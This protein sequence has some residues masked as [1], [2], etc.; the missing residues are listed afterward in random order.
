MTMTRDDKRMRSPEYNLEIG[1]DKPN[2]RLI[3]AE[4]EKGIQ[5]ASDYTDRNLRA[6]NSWHSRWEGMSPDGRKHAD[7]Q[8]PASEAFPWEGA[9]DTRVRTVNQ[10]IRYYTTVCRFAFSGAKIQAT[11]LRPFAQNRQGRQSN[12]ITNLL[13]YQF[14]TELRSDLLR[15]IPIGFNWRNGYGA[16]L[17]ITDWWQCRRLEKIEINRMDLVDITAEMFGL[18]PGEA[19]WQVQEALSNPSHFDGMVDFVQSL[20]PIMT[21][22]EARKAVEALQREGFTTLRVPKTFRNQPRIWAARPG[23][24]AL[25]LDVTGDLQQEPWF[26]IQERVSETDLFDRIET[27]GYD[28]R[29]VDQAVRQK[30]E[31]SDN[32]W[33]KQTAWERDMYGGDGRLASDDGWV[34]AYGSNTTELIHFFHKAHVRGVPA[35]FRTILN[36]KVVGRDLKNP[37]YAWHGLHPYEHGLYPAVESRFEKEHRPIRSSRG[38]AELANNWEQEEKIQA[39]GLVDRTALVHRPPLVGP[40]LREHEITGTPLPGSYLGVNRPHEFSWMPLPQADA[41]PISAIKMVRQRLVEFFPIVLL[42]GVVDPMLVNMTRQELSND[43]L[44]DFERVFDMTRRLDN[45]YLTDRELARFDL[46][47]EELSQDDDILLKF[48]AKSLTEN[49]VKEQIELIGL[50]LPFNQGGTANMNGVF[51]AAMELINPDIADMTIDNEQDA[52][53]REMREERQAIAQAFAGIEEDLPQFGNHELRLKVLY[54]STIHSQNPRMMKR[55]ADNPDTAEILKK[56]EEHY[57]NMIQQYK[58]NPGIGRA[59]TTRAFSKQAPRLSS[60]AAS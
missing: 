49:Y 1:T 56:R 35:L 57:V 8:D 22:G 16:V 18:E 50:V 29:F 59:L 30:G 32:P 38:I 60:P 36:P 34:N 24:D 53:E 44:G 40:V 4:L 10:W 9:S 11:P 52:T 31:G 20:S 28:P 12:K 47:K 51:R 42:E 5:E 17:W 39:D 58:E 45:Q 37:L 25:W 54:E 41:T 46:T 27:D 33:L 7:P 3:L 6:F 26:A 15:E 13:K 14:G 2:V 55:L 43:V 23:V 21:K 19:L 48:D